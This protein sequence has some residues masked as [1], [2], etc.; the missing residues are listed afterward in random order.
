[1][2]KKILKNGKVA[3]IFRK[4]GWY[5]KHGIEALVFDPSVVDMVLRKSDLKEIVDYCTQTYV[6]FDYPV[7]NLEIKWIDN[8]SLF[9][10]EQINN[11]E[12]VEIFGDKSWI[13]A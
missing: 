12:F 5:S 1:M 9:C 2:Q 8:E 7:D 4:Q 6:N 13:K 10:I 11:E 3:I